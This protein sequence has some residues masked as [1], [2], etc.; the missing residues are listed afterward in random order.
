[1]T[2]MTATPV[3]TIAEP[4]TLAVC[5]TC[6]RDG[7]AILLPLEYQHYGAG[8]EWGFARCPNERPDRAPHVRQVLA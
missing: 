6:Q 7:Y 2:Q 1:M 3:A 4:A 8:A 5:V